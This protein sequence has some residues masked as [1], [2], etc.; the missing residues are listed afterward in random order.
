MVRQGKTRE[1]SKNAILYILKA[2][3]SNDD[4]GRKKIMKLM[5]LVDY[6]DTQ[7]NRITLAKTI[8]NTFFIYNYGVFSSDVMKDLSDL[9]KS[10]KLIES[11]HNLKVK[12]G[13]EIII[14]GEIKS[15]LDEVIKK[16]GKRSPR[17]LEDFT[18]SLVKLDRKSKYEYMG[19]NIEAFTVG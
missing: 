12:A 2:L 15:K 6:F 4:N 1:S 18:L 5:F 19:V 10:G 8:G 7:K 17:D 11:E 14:D 9:I 3:R 13:T 16:Y